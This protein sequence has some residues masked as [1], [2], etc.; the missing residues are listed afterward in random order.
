MTANVSLAPKHE[1]G[2]TALFDSASAGGEATPSKQQQGGVTGEA[3]GLELVNDVELITLQDVLRRRCLAKVQRPA[4][5][6][7]KRE[8]H[9]IERLI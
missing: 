5:E 2:Q 3:K 8:L 7:G 4:Q 1:N 9:I 6:F